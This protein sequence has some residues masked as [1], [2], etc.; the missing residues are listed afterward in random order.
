MVYNRHIM[1]FQHI[2]WMCTSF[3]YLFKGI[4]TYCNQIKLYNSEVSGNLCYP[5]LDS[6][7]RSDEYS[8]SL[9]YYSQTRKLSLA[10]YSIT[11]F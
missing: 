1:L 2:Q 9:Q 8:W 11:A 3:Q 7:Q 5:I 10:E 6:I 4:K